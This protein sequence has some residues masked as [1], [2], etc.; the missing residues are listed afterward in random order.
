MS[1][2]VAVSRYTH[3]A[4][5]VGEDVAGIVSEK[6]P[7]AA[8]AVDASVALVLGDVRLTATTVDWLNGRPNWSVIAPV[9]VT[10]LPTLATMGDDAVIAG[11]GAC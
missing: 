6:V 3:S 8:G 11:T 9:R 7:F 5:A 1:P 4:A 10:G 2:E